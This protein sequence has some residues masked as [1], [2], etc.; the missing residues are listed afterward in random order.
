MTTDISRTDV[1]LG[2]L[3]RVLGEA[4]YSTPNVAVRELVQNAHDSIERRRIEGAAGGTP[5]ISVRTSPNERLLIVEDSGAGLTRDEVRAYL[6]TVGSGRTRALRDAGEG[7]SM[8]GYFGLGFLSTFVVASRTEVWTCSYQSPDTAWRFSSHNGETYS[9]QPAE[10]REVGT[11]VTLTLK[12]EHA[13]LADADVLVEL[14]GNYCALLRHPLHVCNQHLNEV[15]PPWR[16]SKERSP[17][18]ERTQALAFAQRFEPNFAPIAAW[19]MGQHLASTAASG[20]LW[21]QDGGSFATS[22][23]RNVSVFVLGMLISNDER[24]LLPPWAGFVGGVVEC[25][26]LKPTAS[27]ETLQKDATYKAVSEAIREELVDGISALPGKAPEQWRRLVSRHNDA[28]RGAALS[29]ESLFAL[30]ADEL[31]MPTNLGDLTIPEILE[32]SNGKLHVT[33]AEKGGFEELMFRSV[34]VPVILGYRYGVLS[35]CQRYSETKAGILVSLGTKEGNAHL[36]APATLSKEEE[37]RLRSLFERS[38]ADLVFSSFEPALLPF[39]LLRDREAL[40]K[41]RIESD[42]ADRRLGAAVLSLARQFTK[43]I[44]DKATSVLHIN[45]LSEP[46]KALLA[47]PPERATLGARLLAPLVDLLAEPAS[48][49]DLQGALTSFG[50]AL[51]TVMK[52]ND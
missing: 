41:K 17:I 1:D 48:D 14:L 29:E 8:I 15:P 12:K 32:Q 21:L 49:V 11:T 39:V 36:L 10:S 43:D 18:R 30:L 24:D 44:E 46:I 42:E 31:T 16:G 47:A 37:E 20:L 6:A 35:F 51:V 19:S 33:H 34:N 9:L 5:R 38:G 28:L 2:G 4:L 23:H 26:T 7:D 50:A 27:R 3:M 45:T 25:D 13:E 22:D 52:G 40:L